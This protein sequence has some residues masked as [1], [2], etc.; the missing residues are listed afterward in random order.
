MKRPANIFLRLFI[1]LGLCSF[2]IAET[3]YVAPY[4]SNRN[5]G[6]NRF[7]WQTIQHA[8]TQL[9]PGDTLLIR[10]G[11]Y[12]E[13]I[14]LPNTM[15]GI[16][17]KR[18]V[19][20][21][22]PG[23][24]AVIDGTDLG[25]ITLGFQSGS[26]NNYLVFDSLE[27]FGA[28]ENA[29]WVEGNHNIIRN[30][31]LHSTGKTALLLIGNHNRIQH[32]EIYNAGWN[33]IGLES[34]EMVTEEGIAS[35]E[36]RSDSNYVEFCYVHDVPNHFGINVFPNP[37]YPQAFINGNVIRYNIIENTDG[38]Y[39]RWNQSFY[40]YGNLVLN[41]HKDGIAF[42]TGGIG[43]PETP[44]PYTESDIKI[45][46]NVFTKGA[47][48]QQKLDKVFAIR[49]LTNE[50]SDIRNNIFYGY[51]VDSLGWE[52][53]VR[54]D[55]PEDTIRNNLF[56]N[57]LSDTNKRIM[58][59]N[60]KNYSLKK[61]NSSDGEHFRNNIFGDPLFMNIEAGD[62]T[63]RAGSPA[64]DSG[65]NLPSPYDSTFALSTGW[66]STAITIERIERGHA[67]IGVFEFDDIITSL[68]ETGTIERSFPKKFFL[69]PNFPNPFNAETT[70]QFD[71][72]SNSYVSLKIF[73][74]LGQEVRVL[75]NSEKTTGSYSVLWDGRDKTGKKA[76][77]GLYFYQLKAGENINTRKMILNQ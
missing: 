51:D 52:I 77:S 6:S 15:N 26:L 24:W 44:I 13:Q 30:L 64:I 72:Q 36:L 49:N 9:F 58:L 1:L 5:S 32:C 39:G 46:H 42:A 20:K 34:R 21:S 40:I 18:I 23:E 59:Y 50:G 56:Y 4:G 16:K 28:G 7:P 73:N 74:L 57:T 35:S 65:E 29:L 33:G 69:Y 10:D 61:M 71:L 63:V 43:Q 8:F 53:F 3:Y 27:V 75:L 12:K 31:V 55:S 22:Y 76:A 38:I 66:D 54:H 2:S 45:Y 68:P 11:I 14:T 47:A 17:D 67:D 70:I 41:S 25:K 19:V 62:F 37:D 48:E 60:G